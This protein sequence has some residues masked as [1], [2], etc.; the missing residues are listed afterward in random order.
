MIA[1]L[2]GKRQLRGVDATGRGRRRRLPPSNKNLSV[3]G[4]PHPTAI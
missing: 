1:G 2:T 3:V 4:W